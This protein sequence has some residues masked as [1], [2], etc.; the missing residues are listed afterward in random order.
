M[1]GRIRLARVGDAATIAAI[2]EPHVAASPTSFETDVPSADEI[3]RRITERLRSHP[4]LVY[5]ERDEIAGYAYATT[6]RVRAAYQWSVET[7]AYVAEPFRRRRIGQALY[8]SL[9][10]ILAAQGYVNA[11]AGITLPNPASVALHESVGFEHIGVYRRIGFKLGAWHDV[12]WWQLALQ[13]HPT[14]PA[15]PLPLSHVVEQPQFADMLNAGLP[16]IRPHERHEE[17]L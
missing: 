1:A 9:F 13:P 2:Y 5:E 4:W 10:R 14:D 11:Y 12:G 17:R 16:L 15:A 8:T 7:S 6:H 3:A